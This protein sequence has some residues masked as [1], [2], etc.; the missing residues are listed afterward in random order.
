MSGYVMVTICPL[1]DGSV[2]ISWYPISDVLKQTSP[3][4]VPSA[5]NAS[6]V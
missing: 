4:C 2:R 1:Y 6:P 5:P 3:S